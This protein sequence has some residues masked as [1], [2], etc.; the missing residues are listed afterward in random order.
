M[1]YS[2]TK[3]QQYLLGWKF[4]FHVDHSALIYLVS[5]ALLTG[6]ITRWTLLLQELEFNIYHR[7]GVEHAVADCLSR[8]ESGEAGDGVQ[9]EFPD[10]ELFRVT[11]QPATDSTA[12]EEDKWLTEMHQFLSTGLPPNKMDRDERKRLMVRSRHVCL[13]QET[14]YHKEADGIWRHAVRSDEKDIILREA[15][16]GIAGGHYAGDATSLKI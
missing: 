4:S 15:H 8:M 1:V 12:V 14:L 9:D 5:K 10:S 3:Y 11:T 7:P 6:K 16:C 13:I 2:V